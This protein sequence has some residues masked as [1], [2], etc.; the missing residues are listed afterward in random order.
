[1]NPISFPQQTNVLAKAQPQYRVLP[2]AERLEN[3]DDP[4]SVVKMTCKYELSDLELQQIIATRCVYISQFGYGFHPIY[5]QVDSPFLVVPV[6]YRETEKGIYSLYIPMADK[7][8][9]ELHNIPLSRCIDAV[10]NI[11]PQAPLTAESIQFVEKQTL[12]IDENGNIT[13]I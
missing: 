6:H 11:D 9:I 12:A 5:P 10:L 2:I 13:S 7:S 4:Q 3:P 1:M 8:I